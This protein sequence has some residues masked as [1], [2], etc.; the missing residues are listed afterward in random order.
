MGITLRRLWLLCI[1]RIDCTGV[2]AID[3][4]GQ[5]G[6]VVNPRPYSYDTSNTEGTGPWLAAF[7]A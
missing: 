7:R 6:R 5:T 1:R 3:T 4:Q 2:S